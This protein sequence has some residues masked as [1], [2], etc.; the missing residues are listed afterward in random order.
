MKLKLEHDDSGR[1]CITFD[2][3]VVEGVTQAEVI[4]KAGDLMRL[5]VE[6]I[7]ASRMEQVLSAPAPAGHAA[8]TLR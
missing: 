4:A 5:T 3:V 8:S 6:V 7:E 1:P 2:G